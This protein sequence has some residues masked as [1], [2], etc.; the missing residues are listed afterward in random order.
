M[1][2]LHCAEI[3]L[4]ND[5]QHV[6]NITKVTFGIGIAYGMMLEKTFTRLLSTV[7]NLNDSQFPLALTLSDGLVG[8]GS[9]QIYNQLQESVHFNSKNFFY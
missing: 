6:C 3:T 2:A 4:T 1:V 9:H 5:L 8:S 7:P